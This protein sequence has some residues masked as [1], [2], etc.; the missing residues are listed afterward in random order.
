MLVAARRNFDHLRAR[1]IIYVN[2]QLIYQ[3]TYIV[4]GQ[5]VSLIKFISC[6]IK[7]AVN[8]HPSSPLSSP[9]QRTTHLQFLTILAH[10]LLGWMY[11]QRSNVLASRHGP[12]MVRASPDGDL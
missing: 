1:L 8:L 2:L 10:L 6:Y 7:L 11:R 4:G 3:P 9:P 5:L 12:L